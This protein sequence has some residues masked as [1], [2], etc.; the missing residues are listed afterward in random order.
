[1]ASLD[2]ESVIAYAKTFLTKKRMLAAHTNPN[3]EKFDCSSFVQHVFSKY[4][5]RLPRTVRDQA[6]FGFGIPDKGSLQKGDLLFFYVPERFPSNDIPGHVG[7]YM[8]DGEMIHCL[9]SPRRVLISKINTPYK[10]KTF[11]FAKRV[12]SLDFSSAK[13]LTKGVSGPFYRL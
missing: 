9:P 11:L 7:I 4:G 2:I 5:V 10:E 8:R 12:F 1:M 13:S 6:Q 3:T